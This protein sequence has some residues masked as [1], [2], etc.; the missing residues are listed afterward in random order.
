MSKVIKSGNTQVT[1]SRDLDNFFTGFLSKVAP[2][3]K[4]ILE[5][6]VMEIEQD[7]MR[8]WPVRQPVLRR[9]QSGQVIGRQETTQRSY[10][11]FETGYTATGRGEF[12][13][14]VRNTAPYAWAIKMGVESK[15]LRGQDIN[16]SL[17]SRVANEVMFKPAKKASNRV[18]EALASDLTQEIKRD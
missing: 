18:A 1:F 6:T 8:D 14:F 9:N 17:G 10:D 2:N 3:T 16:L 12:I 13:A 4:Q 11:K 15:N 5:A 7:A